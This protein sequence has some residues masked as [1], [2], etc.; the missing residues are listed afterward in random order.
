MTPSPIITPTMH[1][2]TSK[3]V[4]DVESA[5]RYDGIAI[6]PNSNLDSITDANITAINEDFKSP[7]STTL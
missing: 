1:A 3:N 7:F 4:N 2:C 5:I 6:H